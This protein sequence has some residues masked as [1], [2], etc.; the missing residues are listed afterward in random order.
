MCLIS[1]GIA[2]QPTGWKAH[3][4]NRPQPKVV[5]TGESNASASIPSD[6]IVLFDGTDLSQWNGPDE[7]KP[8]WKVKDGVMECFRGAKFLYTKE[9][10]GDIQLHIE[11]ASP[12]GAKGKGQGRGNS[13]VFLPGG[14]EIQVLDSFEN[15]TYADG[16]AS[17]I[18]GQYPPLANASRGPGKWQSYDIIYH[19][20]VF[21][22]DEKL[23]KP[24][25]VTVLH[26]GVIVQHAVEALGPTAWVYHEEF[27][28][29]VTEG[30]IGLQDHG[31]PVRFRNIWVR[32][33]DTATTVGE[34]PEERPFTENELEKFPGKYGK[35]LE[36]KASEGKLWLRAL[37]RS[38]EMTA[39]V[40]GTI[41]T[42]GSAGTLKFN[43]DEE[44]NVKSVKYDFDAGFRGEVERR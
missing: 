43:V 11:W 14:V 19:M 26:N 40:D 31:N 30:T 38:L 36:V 17:S 9:K 35:K 24:A 27:D 1:V 42:R 25:I 16:G 39:Y 33:L 28:P 3:D 5:D 6:A 12:E 21:D 20:P 10:F 22:A 23:V 8:R 44:G 34:Y 41:G 32:K 29:K 37:G 15:E 4:K 7:K 2:Q 13:G 18:Y